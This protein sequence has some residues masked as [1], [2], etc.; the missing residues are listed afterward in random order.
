MTNLLS[1]CTAY[2]L[3]KSSNDLHT[4]CAASHKQLYGCTHLHSLPMCHKELTAETQHVVVHFVSVT[5]KQ[6]CSHVH[7]AF[8][9]LH[10]SKRTS[11]TVCMI[12]CVSMCRNVIMCISVS[13]WMCM[14]NSDLL[15]CNALLSKPLQP[16]SPRP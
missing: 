4:S 16:T 3:S 2:T 9:W 5:L 11:M 10:L 1:K 14:S 12:V 6:L 13:M 8:K 7:H 15:S